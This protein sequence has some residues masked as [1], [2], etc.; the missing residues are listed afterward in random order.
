MPRIGFFTRLLED[1][2]ATQRH[3]WALQQVRQAERYGFSTAWIAQHHFDADEGGLPNPWPLLGAAAQATPHF[4]FGTALVALR[5]V[6]AV[7]TAADA[8]VGDVISCHRFEFAVAPGASAANLNALGYANT[9]ARA[10]LNEKLPVLR[11]A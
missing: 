6:S 7:P 10:L 11:D 1:G 8:A 2:T 3:N 9:D 5:D 4:L